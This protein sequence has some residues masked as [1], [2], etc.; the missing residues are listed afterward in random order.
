[1]KITRKPPTLFRFARHNRPRWQAV[2]VAA[3]AL[4]RRFRDWHDLKPRPSEGRGFFRPGNRLVASNV[5]YRHNNQISIVLEAARSLIYAGY[6]L[7]LSPSVR[8]SDT[9]RRDCALALTGYR[10]HQNSECSCHNNPYSIYILSINSRS[11]DLRRC[12][13]LCNGSSWFPV[14]RSAHSMRARAKSR[15][16]V[17]SPVMIGAVSTRPSRHNRSTCSP[18]SLPLVQNQMLSPVDRFGRRNR[19]GQIAASQIRT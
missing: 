5:V 6:E 9:S 3:E 2:L 14:A 18:M 12:H 19:R 4:S 11:T 7:R 10:S 13:F 1:M 8:S 16:P 17:R 15:P